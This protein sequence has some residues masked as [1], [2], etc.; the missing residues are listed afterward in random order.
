MRSLFSKFIF[1]YGPSAKLPL[2]KQSQLDILERAQRRSE[3][4]PSF[5]RNSWAQYLCHKT[6]YPKSTWFILNFFSAI[7]YLPLLLYLFSRSLKKS[8][9]T[10]INRISIF[11]LPDGFD[12][13]GTIRTEKLPTGQ[14]KT[15]YF[16]DIFELIR[17]A[18]NAPYFL[19]KSTWKLAMYMELIELHKPQE[20]YVSQEMNFESSL[21][22]N[23]LKSKSISHN[24]VMHGEKLFNIK[25]AFSS[26]TKIFVWEPYYVELF[27]NLKC[28]YGEY[29]LFNPIPPQIPGAK[30]THALK[31][32]HQ[33]SSSR[34]E[35]KIVLENL[36]NFAQQKK[37]EVIVRPHPRHSQKYEIEELKTK[38]IEIEY[39]SVGIYESIKSARYV[40]SEFS[41]VLYQAHLMGKELVIDNSFPERALRIKELGLIIYEKPHQLLVSS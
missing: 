23:F 5:I 24:N 13:D 9:I 6:L 36:K 35:F 4:M 21:I 30:K 10:P 32:Y 17:K 33:I 8:P 27:E 3:R 29:H 20:I 38:G 19:F 37:C 26:F 39:A 15:K 22:T 40:C 2:P 1:H 12:P 31:Y 25:D 34:D 41:T 16:H 11:R 18:P 14:L 7:F 28:E